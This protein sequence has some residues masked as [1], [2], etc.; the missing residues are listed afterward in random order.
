MAVYQATFNSPIGSGEGRNQCNYKAYSIVVVSK[1]SESPHSH[2][3]PPSIDMLWSQ[4]DLDV[5]TGC[6]KPRR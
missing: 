6:R 3:P 4:A 5:L 2:L 1:S